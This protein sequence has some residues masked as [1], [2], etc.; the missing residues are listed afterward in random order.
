MAEELT[1]LDN[2]FRA[3]EIVAAKSIG[4][5]LATARFPTELRETRWCIEV[6]PLFLR[7]L[8][9][10]LRTLH[11]DCGFAPPVGWNILS[12]A[13]GL[14]SGFDEATPVPARLPRALYTPRY[15]YGGWVRIY[16]NKAAALR[17]QED[18]IGP[19]VVHYLGMGLA[20]G[21]SE[22]RARGILGI[23]VTRPM[24]ASVVREALLATDLFSAPWLVSVWTGPN[25]WVVQGVG[26]RFL[27][28][29]VSPEDECG[30]DLATRPYAEQ[31]PGYDA[32]GAPIFCSGPDLGLE[33]V[34]EAIE[35]ALRLG[36]RL[37]LIWEPLNTPLDAWED[38]VGGFGETP[39]QGFVI[40]GPIGH[41]TVAIQ[42]DGELLR[43][44]GIG[45][46]DY[47]L[48]KGITGINPAEPLRNEHFEILAQKG[49]PIF[50]RFATFAPATTKD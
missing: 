11:M 27:D 12:S 30:L 24:T 33:A 41:Y 45:E 19:L 43:L 1:D 18:V 13:L 35:M 15:N 50:G 48:F 46:S 9:E 17:T 4:V 40:P 26:S 3:I 32:N 16:R 20:G 38:G 36:Y 5:A 28:G 37:E 47:E 8:P 22:E 42:C 14:L 44:E 23:P 10:E 6:A 29:Q 21:F 31:L 39:L 49:T 25:G 2:A 7:L 34:V